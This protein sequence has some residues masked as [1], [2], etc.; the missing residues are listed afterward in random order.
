MKRFLCLLM[1]GLCLFGLTA[2]GN[3]S[4]EEEVTGVTLNI[5]NW[6]DY[7]DPELVTLFEEQNPGVNVKITPLTS[8]EEMIT[9]LS[10]KDSIYDLC[11]PSDYAIE[12]LIK[13][14]LL[15][16]LDKSKIPNMSHI[17]THCLD[18]SFDKGNTYSVPYMWGTVGILY[19]TTMVTDPVDSWDILWNEK[20][21]RDIVMYDSVRDSMTVALKRL[22][23]SL[24]TTDEKELKE[25]GDSLKE[26]K[27]LVQNYGT[28]EIKNRMA[29]DSAALSVVYSGDAILAMDENENLSYV[30]PKEGSNIWYDNMVIMK[31]T[32]NADLAHKF[33][34]FL[35]DPEVAKQNT[36]Y[37]G[38]TTTNQTAFD[39]LD[40]YYKENP[41]Y[42][43]DVD[44]L[45]N[46]E[47]YVDL[48][49]RIRLYDDI[50]TRLKAY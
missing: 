45:T 13:D 29:S 8:N 30:V 34:N 38:Y 26:Q 16:E 21:Y 25:A 7:I 35:C 10:Q 31:N 12:W 49:D 2:C 20:Y 18:K 37:I 42:A 23:Y 46:C 14:D 47:V 28:D 44:A 1:C 36:E 9:V 43:P 15:L 27:K 32:K 33:I 41:A 48:G 39:N 22:G 19:N 4:G 3:N 40:E 11:F 50:W 17:M 24:N 5:L 6:D